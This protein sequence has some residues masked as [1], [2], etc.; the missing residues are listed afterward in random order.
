[1]VSHYYPFHIA[2]YLGIMHSHKLK[3]DLWTDLLLLQQRKNLFLLLF[4]LFNVH[5]KILEIVYCAL[6]LA[7]C[8]ICCFGTQ[9]KACEENQQ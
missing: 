4:L 9:T 7:L 8:I 5:N 2:K 1:M 3:W 6:F